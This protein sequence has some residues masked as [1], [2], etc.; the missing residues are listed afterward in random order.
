MQISCL[1]NI[2]PHFAIG[3]VNMPLPTDEEIW[4]A[5]ASTAHLESELLQSK[6]SNFCYV[7]G[8]LLSNGK[9]PRL[10]NPFGCALI[11]HTLYRYVRCTS[12]AYQVSYSINAGVMCRQCTD[13][14]DYDKILSL[15]WA[16][17]G[18]PYRL[19]FPHIFKQ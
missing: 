3:E 10:L 12:L 8:S 4:N 13:A 18:S 6:P 1:L 2:S 5:P 16:S 7:L 9:L 19:Q 15:P 17:T 14:C 11:A